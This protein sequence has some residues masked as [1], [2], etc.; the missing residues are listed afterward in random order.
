MASILELSHSEARALLLQ[1]AS[2]N[3]FALPPYFQFQLLLSDVSRILG[4]SQGSSLYPRIKRAKN[5]EGVNY[6]IL[7][8]KDGR[9][10]WRPLQLINPALYV[11]LTHCFTEE[12][13]WEEIR[14]RFALFQKDER[15]Q[16]VG[17]PRRSEDT[18]LSNKQEMVAHW[19]SEIEQQ[20]IELAL[21]Y[22]YIF[23]TDISD[24][25]SSIYTHSI[26]WAVYGK[27]NAKRWRRDHSL[28]GNRVDQFLQA[29]SFGQTNGIPQGSIL[30]DFTAEILLGHIDRLLSER[31]SEN[32]HYQILRYRD[33]YRIFVNN[34]QTGEHIL[35]IL[36]EILN[37]HGMCLSPHKT[38]HSNDVISH[39][40]KTDKLS[41]LRLPFTWNSLQGQLL[42]I[43]EF[44]KQH[45]NSGSLEKLLNR[46]YGR[47][48]KMKEEKREFQNPRVLISIATD[49]AYCN[50]RT[51]PTTCGIISHLLSWLPTQ[52]ER[53]EIVCKIKKRFDSLPNTGHLQVWLQRMSLRYSPIS[54][55]ERLCQFV[56]APTTAIWNTDWIDGELAEVISKF[57]IVDREILREIGPIIEHEE[58]ALF[59]E[60][61]E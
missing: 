53:F 4:S 9:Y 24:C 55:E 40:I 58:F 29:M 38:L 42:A 18:E 39:S 61:Y 17:I 3:D 12:L 13:A 34:P 50:P 44:S 19:W 14:G 26:P 54:F 41:L 1:G 36:T 30:M 56:A 23:H 60:H 15:V 6:T 43:R 33:D 48:K 8:N 16:A 46:F 10:A 21:E 7:N 47:V 49:L 57:D 11:G 31:I 51:Y 20:S 28:I 37:E 5:H 45:Q 22:E 35:K 59:S 32:E 2:Y 52:D 25:Y 27:D